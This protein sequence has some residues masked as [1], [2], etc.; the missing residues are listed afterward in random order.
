MLHDHQSTTLEF[1]KRKPLRRHST[2][3]K[4]QD[5]MA[6]TGNQKPI[7]I[8]LFDRWLLTCVIAVALIG[9]M[10]VYSASIVVSEKMFNEPFYFVM[11]Q[12]VFIITGLV[13]AFFLLRVEMKQWEGSG[14]HA[15]S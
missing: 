5:G 11:H 6:N 12:I 14:G 10:M 1:P 2:V 7:K 8:L 13:L 15:K 9:I 4:F 3:N